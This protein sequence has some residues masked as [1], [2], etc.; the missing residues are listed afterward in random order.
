MSSSM[1]RTYA[2]RSLHSIVAHDLGARIVSGKLAPG[3]VL[4]TEA[5]LSESLDVSRTALREAIKILSAKGL[6]E[7][8]PKTGTRVKPRTSWNLLDPD[9]LSWH[10]PDPDPAFLYGLFETRMIIEPNTAAMAAERATEEQLATI[11]AAYVG[12]E[13]A[14]LGTDAVYMTDLAFHQAILDA[15]GN[16]FMKSFGM[17]IETALIGSFRLSSGGPKAH[18]KS[19]PDHLAVYNAIGQR[20]PGDAREA[21]RR[22]LR[23]TMRQLR[24]QLGM[25][26]EH[27]WDVIGL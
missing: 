9:V 2:K 19:L 1:S 18:V 4:P 16:D 21:M 6:I 24:Q 22:L 12:M 13:N 7:S 20:E 15:S 26:S 27:D 14:E 10:F 11:E 8:R 23:R 25:K 5:A 3:E 17:L